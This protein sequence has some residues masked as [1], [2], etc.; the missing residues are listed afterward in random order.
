[1]SHATFFIPNHQ[2]L[3]VFVVYA[4]WQKPHLYAASNATSNCGTRYPS[5]SG[6]AGGG[7][8]SV[9][10]GSKRREPNFWCAALISG[11]R[12]WERGGHLE[13]EGD[14]AVLVGPSS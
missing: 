11:T 10:E 1:M 6:S 2:P 8:G 3:I 5:T 12:K 9:N 14:F 13:S 4:F 7:W